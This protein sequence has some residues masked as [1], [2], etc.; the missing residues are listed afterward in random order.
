MSGPGRG[1][2]SE[3]VTAAD[4]AA[5]EPAHWVTCVDAIARATGSAGAGLF[6]PTPAGGALANTG[7]MVAG[8][9]AYF[10]HW[11]HQ[12]PWN[13]AARGTS[14]FQTAGEILLGTDYISDDDY[15]RTAYF[16]E[17]ARRYDSGHKLFLKVCDA[18]DPVAP[19]THLTLTRSFR[20]EPFGDTE[21]L[22]IKWLWPHL[23]RT[24]QTY[25]LLRQ[26]GHVHHLAESTIVGVLPHPVFV[27]REDLSV[28]FSSP[29]GDALI[30]EGSWLRI[31]SRKINRIGQLGELELRTLA[32]QAAKGIGDRRLVVKKASEGEIPKRAT[33]RTVP[34]ANSP[35]H[36]AAWPYAVGMFILEV[37]SETD[38][39]NWIHGH[40]RALFKLTAKES[41]VFQQLVRGHSPRSIA[42]QLGVGHG[43][44]RTHLTKL[45]EKTGAHSLADLIRL[46]LT[47]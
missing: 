15:R 38:D 26:A 33:L 5:T 4:A 46:A 19:V 41:E 47:R 2:L 35:L 43:T 3:A 27:A 28:D 44:V 16:N 17:H 14:L 9:R 23:Q 10:D 22:A 6:I 36:A 12:D 21:R 8:E 45:R 30:K 40:L 34:I 25:A 11:I 13:K 18:A 42:V 32:A 20:Q 24:V 1:A 31:T 37:P 29:F 7:T 39:E